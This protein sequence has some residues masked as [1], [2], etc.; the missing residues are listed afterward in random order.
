MTDELM[1]QFS[2]MRH[3]V[4]ALG[5]LIKSAQAQAPGRAE[6]SDHSAAVHVKVGAD[7]LPESFHI[8]TDWAE[9]I[10]PEDL[11][12]S[13]LE[14]FG[15]ATTNR[16]DAWTENL[17]DSE[18]LATVR[19]L[20]GGPEKFPRTARNRDV[21][22]T[23]SDPAVPEVEPRAPD[24][25]AEDAIKAFENVQRSANTAPPP[26]STG[27]GAA[28]G[29]KVSITLSK[30]ALLSCA[31]D[32]GWAARQTATGLMNSLATALGR[33]KSDL[34]GKT[35]AASTMDSGVDGLFA[36]AIALLRNPRR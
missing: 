25:I 1:A 27:T 4:S 11:A 13:V 29:R 3:Y 12:S 36:E 19:E 24:L 2:R 9:W 22:A 34:A 15:A 30:F 21:P 20:D 18:F 16:L 17:E 35:D 8:T 33:A 32:P 31:I 23:A 28:A 6:G 14:A 10:T 7:G 26:E 5:E